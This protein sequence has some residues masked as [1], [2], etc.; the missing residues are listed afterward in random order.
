[1]GNIFQIQ[2]LQYLY[3]LHTMLSEILKKI[4]GAASSNPTWGHRKDF[5]IP[6]KPENNRSSPSYK[7]SSDFRLSAAAFEKGGENL[8]NLCHAGFTD[9]IAIF[10][11]ACLLRRVSHNETKKTSRL[12]ETIKMSLCSLYWVLHCARNVSLWKWYWLPSCT[13]NYLAKHK[14][15]LYYQVIWIIEKCAAWLIE[16][17]EPGRR[18]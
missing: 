2:Y 4:L 9:D 3:D 18:A 12:N 15:A 13:A 8:Y 16:S 14:K 5:A 1:M 10:C 6:T 7:I 17:P 11:G